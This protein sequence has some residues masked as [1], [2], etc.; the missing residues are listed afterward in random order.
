M[1]KKTIIPFL[2]I[3]FLAFN[4]ANSQD[5]FNALEKNL[6]SLSASITGLNNSVEVSVNDVSIQELL[7]SISTANSVNLSVDDKL[8][9]KVSAN[10]ASVKVSDVLIYLCRQF[11]LTLT[12]TGNIITVSQFNS[13]YI[14]R[15]I[16]VDYDTKRNTLSYDLNNDSLYLVARAISDVTGKNIIY[17]PNINNKL[18]T[19]YLQNLPLKSALEKLAAINDLKLSELQDS[20]YFLE[21]FEGSASNNRIDKSFKGTKK[22]NNSLSGITIS[23]TN[24][25]TADVSNVPISEVLAY[26]SNKLNISYSEVSEL[27][28]STSINLKNATFNEFL[29]YLF[30]GTEFSFKRDNMIY[31]VGD[32]N[33]DVLKTSRVIKLNYR[34]VEKITDYIPESLK[35]GLELKLFAELN[36]I[37]VYGEDADIFLLEKF[38]NAIDQVVPV[39]AIEVIIVDVTD[40]K[41][42]TT[43]IEA[44]LGTAP[45]QTSGTVFPNFNM[46]LGSTSLNNLITG[47][48]GFGAVNIGNVTPNFYLKLK[49]LDE[50]GK[51]NIRSTPQ[52]ATLNGHES[53]VS[54]GKTE[55]Y[56]E[57]TNNV[58]GT[59][60]PQNIITQ[61]YKSVNADLIVTILPIVSGDEQITLDVKVKQSSFTERISP[62]AP[63]GTVTRDFKSLIRVK[64]SDMVILGGLEENSINDSGSGVPFLSRIPI[65]KWFFSSRNYKKSKSKLTIFIKP[66]VLY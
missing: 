7:R 43:G 34:T 57:T 1:N 42:L 51:L 20:V 56:L 64:N 54:I 59:Q 30:D 13:S 55:Y 46:T 36:S 48:N 19:G 12:F 10:F 25:I 22:N 11:N 40:S 24:L 62:S 29:Y 16:K 61:M 2:L 4:K 28:G 23:E 15:P 9:Y 26:V 32:K 37:V 6:E 45:S 49:A 3:F 5:R 27:L 14:R 21:L 52:L 33:L 18:L 44:G 39:I 31:L 41:T 38:I 66:T 53:T 35:K 65:L 17:S 8:N 50:Q 63:P 47:I 58:I 60:N